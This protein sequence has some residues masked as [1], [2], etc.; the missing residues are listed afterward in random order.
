M[1]QL[2]N[3]QAR[4]ITGMYPCTPIHS[5]LS[6]AGLIPAQ[7]LLD[8]RQR[9]YAY[10]PLTFPDQHPTKTILPISL[11]KRDRNSQPGEQP[12]NT[13]LQTEN[14][15]PVLYGQ[16]LIWQIAFNHAIDPAARVEPVEPPETAI[17]FEGQVVMESPK[18]T[19]EK[20]KGDC[21][22]LLIQTDRSKLDQGNIGAAICWKDKAR[23]QWKKQS[24]FLGKNK[25]ALNTQLWAILKA[26][27]VALKVLD[28]K[29]H[30]LQSS[31]THK[32]Q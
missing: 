7:I 12:V 16:Q 30:Q 14:T 24:M 13:L 8:Y 28:K 15:R 11:R 18:K 27:K 31:A 21:Q 20:A 25:E 5:L 10:W 32:K 17:E 2:L 29:K 9:M 23:D 22:G 1:Q 6:E 4:S 3:H 19:F 26:L